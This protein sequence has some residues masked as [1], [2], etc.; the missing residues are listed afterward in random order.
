[1][2][3]LAAGTVAPQ[4]AAAGGGLTGAPGGVTVNGSPYRHV[5][6][7]AGFPRKL[8]VVERIDRRDGRWIPQVE[9]WCCAPVPGPPVP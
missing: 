4:A 9:G 6:I 1:M 7:S 8:T 3:A 5:A 2:L